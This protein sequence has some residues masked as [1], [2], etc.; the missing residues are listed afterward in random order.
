MFRTGI[1]NQQTRVPGNESILYPVADSYTR[2]GTYGDDNYGSDASLATKGNPSAPVLSYDREA[3][4]KFDTSS[5]IDNIV[6]ATLRI[7]VTGTN[8]D[9]SAVGV[10]Q[11]TDDSWTELGIT[12]N[13]APADGNL[14][15]A[16]TVP[17]DGVGWYEFNVTEYL[18]SQADPSVSFQL[19]NT[20]VGSLTNISF[21]SREG[22]NPPEL[23]LRTSPVALN[24]TNLAFQVDAGITASY[25]DP[26]AFW[27]DTEAALN[28]TLYATPTYHRI[29][30]ALEFNGTSQYAL[31]ARGPSYFNMTPGNSGTVE[32]VWFGPATGMLVANHRHTSSMCFASIN[33]Q[34]NAIRLSCST[35][36][37]APY[38]YHATSSDNLVAGW[39][40][41]CIS[42]DI[43]AS[44]GT[45]NVNIC[46]N[47]IFENADAPIVIDLPVID[48]D[49]EIARNRNYTWGTS[50][51]AGKIA[52]VRLYSAPIS[53][54]QME[55]NFAY[56]E[57]RLM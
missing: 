52:L 28:G 1:L 36:T 20:V 49:L 54:A 11:I 55:N 46:L 12:W 27:V 29:P 22:T 50:Y 33:V 40:H 21:S 4:L 56:F 51:F 13:N 8:T 19:Q 9:P 24:N 15:E 31:F 18:Q 10:R 57:D 39:N 25:S 23:V 41:A 42:Y 5:I 3:Y 34:A 16:Q 17:V 38:T 48:T 35:K 32:V 14:I 37:L 43:P 7:Y 6:Q 2:S 26:S 47:G 53:Q 44:S 45:M 30:G